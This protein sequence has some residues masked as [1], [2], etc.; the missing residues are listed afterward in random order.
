MQNIFMREISLNGYMDEVYFFCVSFFL[1]CTALTCFT[2]MYNY[3]IF[4]GGVGVIVTVVGIYKY[5]YIC[6]PLGSF[7]KIIHN[8]GRVRV[9]LDKVLG[10]FSYLGLRLLY[11]IK[12]WWNCSCI[13]KFGPFWFI[14]AFNILIALLERQFYFIWRFFFLSGIKRTETTLNQFLLANMFNVYIIIWISWNRI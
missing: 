6:L 2:S 3:S 5:M 8:C 9:F 14:F 13:C 7:Y 11:N 10:N 12:N 1:C 4:D